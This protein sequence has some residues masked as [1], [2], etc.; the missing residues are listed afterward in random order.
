MTEPQAW[1]AMRTPP[2]GGSERLARAL[3]QREVPRARQRWAIPASIAATCS[4]CVA[5]GI[6]MHV[7]AAPRLA[8]ERA[9]QA[10]LAQAERDAARAAPAAL[11]ELPSSRPDVRILLL[12][13]AP[14]DGP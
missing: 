9:L 11:R 14:D 7:H 10:S 13:P 6:A 4:L 12:E 2:A 1:G 5:A 8:F 3:A